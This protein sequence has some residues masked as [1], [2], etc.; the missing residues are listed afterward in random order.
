MLFAPEMIIDGGQ[1]HPR[2][3][4]NVSNRN[5]IEALLAKQ[6]LRHVENARAGIFQFFHTFVSNDCIYRL[7]SQLIPVSIRVHLWFSPSLF[8]SGFA[9]NLF[10]L[11][12]ILLA[13]LLS[14]WFSPV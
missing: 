3:L 9:L 8:L 5:P 13:I 4:C 12:L 2:L 10:L 7:S 14:L 1:V 11:L 6:F